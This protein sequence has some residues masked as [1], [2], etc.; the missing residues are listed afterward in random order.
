M[1]LRSIVLIGITASLCTAGALAAGC[2][3]D[4]TSVV[5]PT[6]DA[7]GNK[8]SGGNVDSGGQID[9]GGNTD[10]GGNDAATLTAHATLAS[11]SDAGTTGAASFTESNG[12]VGVTVTVQNGSPGKHGMHVHLGTDCT[13]PGPHYGP[14][15]GPYHGEWSIVLDDAGTGTFMVGDADI[16]VSNGPVGVVGH[17]L[18]LHASPVDGGPSPPPRISCGVITTP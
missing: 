3:D 17:A 11:V 8:D 13:N 7:G 18:V 15:G 12:L 5:A 2:S 1:N 14:D 16:T 4:T 9:S 6:G 10:S